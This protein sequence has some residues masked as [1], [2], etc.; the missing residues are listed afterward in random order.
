MSIRVSALSKELGTTNKVLIGFLAEEYPTWG[1][2]DYKTHHSKTITDLY[3]DEIAEKFERYLDTHPELAGDERAKKKADVPAE[4]VP[5]SAAPIPENKPAPAVPPPVPPMPKPA[6][7][8]PPPPPAVKAAPLPP[9]VA[10]RLPVLFSVIFYGD[11]VTARLLMGV[12]LIFVAVVCSE[13]KFA[14][15][16]K[17]H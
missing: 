17:K 14:F 2:S 15:L 16:R 9:P 8:V 4:E 6:P 7:V 12:G 5:E 13:T 10:S 1:I 3:K 11:P